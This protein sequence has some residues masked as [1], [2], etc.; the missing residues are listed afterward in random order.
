MNITSYAIARLYRIEDEGK[1]MINT[2][3]TA[4]TPAERLAQAQG[5][6]PRRRTGVLSDSATPLSSQSS[7]T[8]SDW[9]KLRS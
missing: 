7:I 4:A 3:Y 9:A 5:V 2:S 6:G 8:S 1:P